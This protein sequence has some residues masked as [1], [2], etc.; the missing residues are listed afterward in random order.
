VHAGAL[1]TNSSPTS[2]TPV[3]GTIALLWPFN[4]LARLFC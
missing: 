1:L 4:L 2:A 3:S